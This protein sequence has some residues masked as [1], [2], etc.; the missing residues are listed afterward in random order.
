MR[1]GVE[2]KRDTKARRALDRE[3]GFLMEHYRDA[4]CVFDENAAAEWGRLMREASDKN[5]PLA[6]HDSMISAIARSFGLKVLT[7][8]WKDFPGSVTVDLFTD[9]ERPAWTA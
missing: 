5:R 4:V 3:Y 6:H 1:R 9:Q 2:L 7:Q 8:N